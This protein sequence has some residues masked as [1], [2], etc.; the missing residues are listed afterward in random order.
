[1]NHDIDEELRH[2]FEDSASTIKTISPAF[3]DTVITQGSKRRRARR[4]GIVIGAAATM[5]LVVGVVWQSP[6]LLNNSAPDP[7]DTE[8]T[9]TQLGTRFESPSDWA[10]TLPRGEDVR[11]AYAVGQTLYAGESSVP[12]TGPHVKATSTITIYDPAGGGWLATVLNFGD[13]AEPDFRPQNGIIAT[14]GTFTPFTEQPHEFA[15]PL[16]ASPDGTQFAAGPDIRD[17][18]TGAIVESFPGPDATAGAWFDKGIVYSAPEFRASELK[19]KLKSWI[20]QPGSDPVEISGKGSGVSVNGI[21]FHNDRA[22]S[23]VGPLAE[24]V[25]TYERICEGAVISVSPSGELALTDSYRVVA[26]ASGEVTALP[27]PDFDRG[28]WTTGPLALTY[29]EDDDNVVIVVPEPPPAGR[30]IGFS[31]VRCQIS[32]KS[33]ERASERLG[34]ELGGAPPLSSL[35]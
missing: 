32:T 15:T 21:A 6:Q 4:Q 10:A 35:P 9:T 18:A 26:M 27:V 29:W 28:Y 7:A 8:K 19:F 17:V 1:M 14:D 12:I 25:A 16:L 5:A 34:G 20:W 22:C 24:P 2:L 3:T 13:Q 33:C 31:Y 30:D 11:A 23:R